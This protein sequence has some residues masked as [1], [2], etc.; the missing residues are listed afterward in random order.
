MLPVS[1]FSNIVAL[2][3]FWY[4]SSL[5]NECKGSCGLMVSLDWT[6]TGRIHGIVNECQSRVRQVGR[7]EVWLNLGS[8]GSFKAERT[9]IQS[10]NLVYEAEYRKQHKWRHYNQSVRMC[11]YSRCDLAAISILRWWLS[12]GFW[13]V[14]QKSLWF[15]TKQSN[16]GH[17]YRAV[18]SLGWG[19][20][21][22]SL[23]TG[24]HESS[25][26]SSLNDHENIDGSPIS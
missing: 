19:K 3:E 17:L 10:S 25:F 26:T 12:R 22:C 14:P 24:G 8:L 6:I 21:R 16:P 9:E 23:H 13:H 15:S 11:W 4:K 18:L 2:I 5:Q 7:T 20:G 1:K